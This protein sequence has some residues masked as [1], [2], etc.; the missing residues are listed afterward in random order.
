MSLLT[1]Q[2]GLFHKYQTID[3]LHSESCR[4]PKGHDGQKESKTDC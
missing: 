2:D 4:T 1:Q 3:L